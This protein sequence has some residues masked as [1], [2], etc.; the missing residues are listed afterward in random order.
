LVNARQPYAQGLK[1]GAAMDA[2]VVLYTLAY[3]R[4]YGFK[5]HSG[6]NEFPPEAQ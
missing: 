4:V 1:I 6:Q 5:A 3:F 2:T